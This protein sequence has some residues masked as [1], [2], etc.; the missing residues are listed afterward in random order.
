MTLKDAD[1]WDGTVE[2]RGPCLLHQQTMSDCAK[3]AE[4]VAKKFEKIETQL[5]RTVSWPVLVLLV[6]ISMTVM[7][8][9]LAGMGW[10]V[11]NTASELKDAQATVHRRV[12]ENQQI[13]DA[14]IK[15]LNIIINKQAIELVSR[16]TE[17]LVKTDAMA[18]QIRELKTKVENGYHRPTKGNR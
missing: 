3:K 14:A 10:F 5:Y 7:A 4:D 18:Q 16:Q 9:G 8:A 11:R 13:R 2:R 17:I 15:D 1:G 6:S 12:T